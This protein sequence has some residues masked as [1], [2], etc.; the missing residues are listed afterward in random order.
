MGGRPR[1][2]KDEEIIWQM[3][4]RTDPAFGA[5]EIGGFVGMSRQGIHDR[6]EELEERELVDSKQPGRDRIWWLTEKGGELA[7]ESA[8]GDS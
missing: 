8:V 6:L 5:T 7:E 4:I 1:S 2:V 3:Y